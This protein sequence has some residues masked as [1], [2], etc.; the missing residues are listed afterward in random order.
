VVLDLPYMIEYERRTA[1]YP[2]EH[3]HSPSA[4]R[5]DPCTGPGGSGARTPIILW[6]VPSSCASANGG[7]RSSAIGWRPT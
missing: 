4:T 3:H 6:I 1:A 5:R 2:L 7:R